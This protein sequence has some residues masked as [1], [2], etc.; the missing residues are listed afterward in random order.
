M[1]EE[2]RRKLDEQKRSAQFRSSRWDFPGPC[3][4][5]M[6][7][8]WTSGPSHVFALTGRGTRGWGEWWM[9]EWRRT[10]RRKRESRRNCPGPRRNPK[11]FVTWSLCIVLYEGYFN[12]GKLNDCV[13]IIPRHN[14]LEYIFFI[15]LD[16][17]TF[18]TLLVCHSFNVSSY[19]WQ[20]KR[21]RRKLP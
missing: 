16:V 20:E 18:I 7:C 2:K 1:E 5:L 10:R 3:V 13:A 12:F 9:P 6:V 19:R 11:R 4:C 14:A 15:L 8:R 21:P 17:L